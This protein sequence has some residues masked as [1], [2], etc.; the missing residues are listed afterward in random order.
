MN[1]HQ[2]NVTVGKRFADARKSRRISQR[3][4]G[5]CIDV[6]TATISR[7]ESGSLS[8]TLYQATVLADV[9]QANFSELVLGTSATIIDLS[10]LWPQTQSAI[11]RHVERLVVQEQLLD[12]RWEEYWDS[13]KSN[14]DAPLPPWRQ[15]RPK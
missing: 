13:Y 15:T 1:M 10:K 7:I 8:P 4:A 6:S 2:F 14:I 9:Y 5:E 12:E 11:K 3:T